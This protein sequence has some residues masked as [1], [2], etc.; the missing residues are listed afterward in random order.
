M[1]SCD[2]LR[3]RISY[4]CLGSRCVHV[5][6][7]L[8]VGV[9]FE[10]FV[11]SASFELVGVSVNAAFSRCKSVRTCSFPFL[12]RQHLLRRRTPQGRRDSFNPIYYS[13]SHILDVCVDDTE[14]FVARPHLSQK[15]TGD[16]GDNKSR[17]ASS[18]HSWSSEG[19]P[20]QRT[21]CR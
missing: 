14:W 9:S 7:V 15:T 12:F 5:G 3:R 4:R 2:Y 1:Y 11:S 13:I 21:V 16:A 19:R 18:R 8:F 20:L 6:K 17:Y 10:N